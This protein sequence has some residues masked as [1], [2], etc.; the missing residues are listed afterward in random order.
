M[1]AKQIIYG[2][3][4]LLTIALTSCG[5]QEQKEKKVTSKIKVELAKAEWKKQADTYRFSGKVEADQH[6]GLSTRIMGQIARIYVAAGEKVQ[7]GQLLLQIHD[8]DIRAKK[9]QV[10]ANKIE[11][12]AALKNAKKDFERFNILFEQKSASQKELDDVSTHYQ[13]MKAKLNAVQEMEQE[14]DEMLRY[15]SIRAPYSGIITKKYKNEGDLATPGVPLLAI[16]NANHYKVM[17]RIPETEIAKIQ[18]N[19]LVKVKVAALGED[20]IDAYVKEVNPSALYTGNQF[21]AEIVLNANEKQ[22]EQLHS[23]MHANVIL[24]KGDQS[25]IMVP[26]DVLIHKGQLTGIYTMSQS[27][28]ALLRWIRTGKRWGNQV[29]VLSGLKEGEQYVLS[30]QGKIWDGAELEEK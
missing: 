2:I 25:G 20:L 12:E 22:K 8:Q 7:K 24:E 9:A 23:G 26:D 10:Q 11:V 30:H 1:Y 13:M 16:E 28:T 27:K 18:K 15:A 4:F 21:E 29:E 14:V 17:A 5:S 19:D 3:A 6:S